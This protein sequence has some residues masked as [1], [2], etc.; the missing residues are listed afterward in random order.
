M[1][2]IYLQIISW[3]LL[4][5]IQQICHFRFDFVLEANHGLKPAEPTKNND[6]DDYQHYDD[7][8]E[9]FDPT[10][11]L[12]KKK[13]KHSLGVFPIR[14]EGLLM[15]EGVF[16][17]SDALLVYHK[18]KTVRRTSEIELASLYQESQ[19]TES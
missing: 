1:I 11:N 18:P 12:D 14:F 4:N 6:D 17:S 3:Q 19:A 5:K 9:P 15:C 10:T 2:K 7:D 13:Y 8:Y 16:V